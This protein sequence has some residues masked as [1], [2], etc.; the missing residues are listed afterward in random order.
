MSSV[1]SPGVRSCARIIETP[2]YSIKRVINY[3]FDPTWRSRH[4]INISSAPVLF[5][6]LVATRSS[7]IDSELDLVAHARRTDQ[8]INATLPWKFV[9]TRWHVYIPRNDYTSFAWCHSKRLTGG[10][11]ISQRHT[12]HLVHEIPLRVLRKDL[13]VWDAETRRMLRFDSQW[14]IWKPWTSKYMY[15]TLKKRCQYGFNVVWYVYKFYRVDININ[16]RC[17]YINPI[18]VWI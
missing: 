13:A 3:L 10:S 8:I 18:M 16:P 4:R 2:A 5:F 17:I 12:L 9:R 11:G 1:A 7:W 6:S 15:C 14:I